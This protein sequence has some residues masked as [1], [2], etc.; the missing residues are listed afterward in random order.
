M[1]KRM[2]VQNKLNYIL[3]QLNKTHLRF[4]KGSFCHNVW[5]KQKPVERI[6]VPIASDP[7]FPGPI[8]I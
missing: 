6:P 4:T 5:K 3:I 2:R 1:N 8:N 7:T